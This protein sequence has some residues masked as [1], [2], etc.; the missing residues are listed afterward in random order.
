MNGADPLRFKSPTEI[1]NWLIKN[2]A[3]LGHWL[4]TMTH[5]LVEYIRQGN[6]AAAHQLVDLMVAVT[7]H[8]RENAPLL[9]R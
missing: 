7:E 8:I 6:G 5:Q 3:P 4:I 2:N 1:G 9:I